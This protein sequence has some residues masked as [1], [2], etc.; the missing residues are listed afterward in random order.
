MQSQPQNTILVVL[1]ELIL[2]TTATT[3]G[4]ILFSTENVNFWP[5]FESTHFLVYILLA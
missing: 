4:G 3:S 2:V 5:I 1:T